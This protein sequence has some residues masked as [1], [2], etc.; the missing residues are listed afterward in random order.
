MQ[1]EDEKIIKLDYKN[2]FWD[3][4]LLLLVLLNISGGI[5]IGFNR[6]FQEFSLQ[7]DFMVGARHSKGYWKVKFLIGFFKDFF[8]KNLNLSKMDT[9]EAKES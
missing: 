8:W 5:L 6:N 1:I 9:K 7:K 2:I 4:F 3:F